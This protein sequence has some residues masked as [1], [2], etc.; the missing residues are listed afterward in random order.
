MPQRAISS[1]KARSKRWLSLVEVMIVLT[2]DTVLL[3]HGFAGTSGSWD[4]FSA[5]LDRGRYRPLA[6][7]LR[8]HGQNGAVR[9]ISFE[10]CVSDLLALA[11]RRFTAIGYSL[12]GRIALQLALAAPERVERLLLVSTRGG[13][14]DR[15]ERDARLARDLELADQIE[16]ESIDQFADQW[17]GGSLFCDDEVQVNRDARK[18]I[19]KNSPAN[20]A[21][22]LRA[23]SVGRMEPLWPRLPEVLVPTT[24][25]AGELDQRYVALASRISSAISGSEL[26]LIPGVGHALPRNAPER[27][28]ALV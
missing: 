1:Q 20:L 23:F 19:E 2:M 15:D 16:R 17:L 5:Q 25:V 7:D 26:E 10:L 6:V 22:A 8:G 28:A 21:C 18:Q 4:S 13:I 27:L 11:P 3:L 12:G 14:E 24:V 9:P